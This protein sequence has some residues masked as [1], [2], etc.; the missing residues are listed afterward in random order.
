MAHETQY[1]ILMYNLGITYSRKF[2]RLILSR[3]GWRIPTRID[4]SFVD[5]PDSGTLDHVPHCEALDS[6][7]LR[8]A[9]GAIGAAHECNVATAFLV[10]TAI[11]SFLGL[12]DEDNK[13]MSAYLVHIKS[14]SNVQSMHPASFNC[15]L[16]E[17]W[18]QT[19]CTDR[20]DAIVGKK[21]HHFVLR[22]RRDVLD[23]GDR[24]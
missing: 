10:A 4:A 8:D 6:L 18:D 1:A 3:R 13:P 7:V 16:A 12:T 11:S 19:V 21:T 15:I 2:M 17:F 14:T 23:D 5:I 20:V 24:S 9:A 22:G